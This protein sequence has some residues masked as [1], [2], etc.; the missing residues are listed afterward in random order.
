M[1]ELR[2]CPFCGGTKLKVDS[3][4]GSNFRVVNGKVEEFHV[5]TVRCNRCHTRGP[6]TSVYLKWGEYNAARIMEDA[7]IE[8]WNR[9]YTPPSE[10]DFDYLSVL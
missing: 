3:K 4:K 7:A 8:A 6:T 5:V 2:E 10:I 1:P 9:R